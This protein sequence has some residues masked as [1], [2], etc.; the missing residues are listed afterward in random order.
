MAAVEPGLQARA[1]TEGGGESALGATAIRRLTRDQSK[2]ATKFWRSKGEARRKAVEREN[3]E[4]T[5]ADAWVAGSSGSETTD[6]NEVGSDGV[7]YG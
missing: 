3:G 6:A 5:H 2:I 4:Q 1:E 7:R